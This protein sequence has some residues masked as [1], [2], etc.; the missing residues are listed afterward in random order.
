MH[1]HEKYNVRKRITRK[2]VKQNQKHANIAG[3][4]LQYEHKNKT[5]IS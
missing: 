1:T 3:D 5:K 2:M 4:N